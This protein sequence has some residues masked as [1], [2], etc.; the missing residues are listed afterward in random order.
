MLSSA[1]SHQTLTPA[2]CW[3]LLHHARCQQEKTKTHPSR[4]ETGVEFRSSYTHVTL[5]FK[6]SWRWNLRTK[7]IYWRNAQ[8]VCSF[9]WPKSNCAHCQRLVGT[10][11][12]PMGSN[13]GIHTGTWREESQFCP[14]LFPEF[15]MKQKYWIFINLL[16][17]K[18]CDM[19]GFARSNGRCLDPFQNRLL[20]HFWAASYKYKAALYKWKS[21]NLNSFY[22]FCTESDI[23]N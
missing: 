7:Q 5:A 23:R 15:G 20:G 6:G 14:F 1:L 10:S 2:L 8:T 19:W 4:Q 22:S 11:E 13:R 3:P 12:L 16:L 18:T 21:N 17:S 9:S